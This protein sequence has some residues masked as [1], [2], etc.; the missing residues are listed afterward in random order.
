MCIHYHEGRHTCGCLKTLPAGGPGYIP[1]QLCQGI[2]VIYKLYHSQP[3]R[4]PES[5]SL[6]TPQACPAVEANECRPGNVVLLELKE[7]CPMHL[8][9]A[10]LN[11][12][13][14]KH[15][16]EDLLKLQKQGIDALKVS[17]PIYLWRQ[18]SGTADA[19]GEFF[20]E[21]GSF[22]QLERYTI[23]TKTGA[24]LAKEHPEAMIPPTKPPYNKSARLAKSTSKKQTRATTA[25]KP[26][27]KTQQHQARFTITSPRQQQAPPN[28]N[29]E[30][31]GLPSPSQFHHLATIFDSISLTQIAK[32]QKPTTSQPVQID[33]SISH[34][35]PT[36]PSSLHGYESRSRLRGG[37]GH[38]NSNGNGS[39]TPTETTTRKTRRGGRKDKNNNNGEGNVKD[40]KGLVVVKSRVSFVNPDAL[41][42][43]AAVQDVGVKHVGDKMTEMFQPRGMGMGMGMGRRSRGVSC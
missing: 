27:A 20:D 9:L 15:T 40:K 16:I 35:T 34:N 12:M 3:G 22:N 26:R 24:Q 43:V 8:G 23:E 29:H 17:F 33:E 1:P 32:P 31:A 2:K 14:T 38:S 11:Q 42:E 41:L 18:V 37:D 6:P 28:L 5:Y 30:T 4:P 36:P 19:E 13:S 7:D 21:H 39:G 25:T 10:G